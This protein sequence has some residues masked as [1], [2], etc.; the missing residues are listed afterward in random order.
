MSP[1]NHLLTLYRS[2]VR[3]REFEEK[4]AEKVIAGEIKTPCHLYVGQEA[5]AAGVCA[6]LEKTDNIFGNHR[7]HG[8]YLAKGGSMNALMAEIYGKETGCS[9]GHGGS[10]H[11][12]QTN[13]GIIG[14]QP[15][16]AGS[17]PI[18][19]GSALASHI[20]KDKKVS[21]VFFG[22]GAVEEGVFHEA[23][24]FAALRKLPIIFVC[25]NNLYSSHLHID[26][27][28]QVNN[29]YKTGEVFGIPGVRVDGND[30]LAV[31]KVAQQAVKRARSGKGPTLIE[32]MTYRMRGHVGAI[33][34]VKD[35]HTND[36]RDVK[37][38]SIWKKRDPIVLFERILTRKKGIDVEKLETIKKS[39]LKEVEKSYEYAIK[40]PY[41]NEKDFSKF[42]Y[43]S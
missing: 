30:V 36:I 21:V 19:V 43:P 39:C 42:V 22:D 37:E 27:R 24:N 8:H 31:L 20:R 9:G 2:M 18:A 40:S 35:V 38:I 26:E 15:L 34:Y 13:V 32:A 3:I 25:E 11:I 16:V 10:M 1:Q 17:L 33:D 4:L 6:S 12:I 29:I 14:A 7:S 5:T 41:P 28:R 23:M